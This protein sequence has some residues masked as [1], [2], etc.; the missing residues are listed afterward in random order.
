MRRLIRTTRRPWTG[1]LI[2][3]ALAVAV[4]WLPGEGAGQA[5]RYP[6]ATPER[7]ETLRLLDAM[8]I[9]DVSAK[10]VSARLAEFGR[11]NPKV[12]HEFWQ[13]MYQ[14]MVGRQALLVGLGDALENDVSREQIRGLL[15]FYESDLGKAAVELRTSLAMQGS[16]LGRKL[17]QELNEEVRAELKSRGYI[18]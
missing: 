14:R 3:S 1:G 7:Q 8:G 11:A 13:E 17:G 12:P 15:E 16:A 10:S 6:A 18:D 2:A 9:R 4:W 5:T